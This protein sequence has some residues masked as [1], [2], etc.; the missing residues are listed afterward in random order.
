M[1]YLTTITFRNDSAEEIHD[2][3]EQLSQ[4][5]YNAQHGSQQSEGRDYDPIGNHCNP[6]IIQKPRHADDHTLYLHAGNTVKDVWELKHEGLINTAISELMFHLKRLK[7]LKKNLKKCP[8]CGGKRYLGSLKSTG[9]P[10][11]APV[12]ICP[13]CQEN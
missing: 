6:V 1:G 7:E 8:T 5:V 12:Q 11:D 13:T 3:P 2:H 10:Y 9:N 4:I